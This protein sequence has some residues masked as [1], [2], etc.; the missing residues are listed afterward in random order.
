MLERWSDWS[1]ARWRFA[2]QRPRARRGALGRAVAHPER[3]APE[4]AY[5]MLKPVGT[6]AALR[7]ALRALWEHD[8]RQELELIEAPALVAW[9][10]EDRLI[11]PRF[12]QRVASALPHARLELFAD[13]GHC[14]QIEAPERFNQLLEETLLSRR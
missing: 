5:E 6:A 2:L 10:A 3:L 14:P 4:T 12:A 9:G 7:E 1:S 8:L 13:T 11:S